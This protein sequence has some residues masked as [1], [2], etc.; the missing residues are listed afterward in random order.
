MLTD[1]QRKVLSAIARHRSPES[2]IA[3]ASAL[4]RAAARR[5]DDLDIFHDAAELVETCA[6]TDMQAL[7]RA[8]FDVEMLPG[9]ARGTI[10]AVVRDNSGAR[11]RL[12]WTTDTAFRFFPAVADETFGWRL[13]DIDLAINK[14][15]ALAGRQEPRDALDVVELHKRGVPLSALAW[16]AAGKDPGLTPYLILEE[17]ARNARLD[18]VRLE[19]EIDTAGA[20]DAVALRTTLHKA[21]AEARA[22]FDTLPPEQMGCLYLDAAQRVH[23]PD[24]A[25]VASGRLYLHKASLNGSWPTASEPP[26]A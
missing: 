13:H 19:A 21:I 17:I 24:P 4:N 2:H 25:G 22:L 16:A 18:P 3:G 5:S 12:E 11:T 1:F 7:T 10:R 23:T 20:I 8:G 15:L 6:A 26:K 9:F 14:V